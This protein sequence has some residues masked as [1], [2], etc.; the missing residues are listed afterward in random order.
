MRQAWLLKDARTKNASFLLMHLSSFL[1]RGGKCVTSTEK[2]RFRE[3]ER[4]GG[5]LIRYRRAAQRL[6]GEHA[7]RRTLGSG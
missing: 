7:E 1:T 5:R 3:D 6:A 2:K 4:M